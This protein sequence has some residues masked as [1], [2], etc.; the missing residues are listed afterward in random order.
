MKKVKLLT[1]ALFALMLSISAYAFEPLDFTLQNGFG[2]LS[3]GNG[4]LK[5]LFRKKQ[6]FHVESHGYEQIDGTFRL[7]QTITFQ[8]KPPQ[9]RFWVLKTVSSNQ[10]NDNRYI[11]TLSNT[12]GSVTGYT[13][14]LRLYLRYRVKGSLVM[15]QTLELMP[16]GKTIDN[17]GKITLFGLPI[18]FL[19]EI[20]TRKN[21]Q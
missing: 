18:G 19:K 16:D 3:E 1:L 20:I 15:H 21:E 17:V 4:T 10:Y 12:S 2:G 6:N 5:L 14:G 7:D 13:D 9:D 8:G 11:G